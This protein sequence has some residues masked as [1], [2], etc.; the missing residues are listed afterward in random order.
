[1]IFKNLKLDPRSRMLYD[2]NEFI[3]HDNKMFEYHMKHILLVR[4]YAIILNKYLGFNLD[5]KKISFIAL[6]H[7]LFK[8]RSLDPKK[9]VSWH[10]IIIP[11]D[12]NR[13]VRSNLDILEKYELDDY[14]NSDMQYHALSAGIFLYKELHITD[15][16]IIYPV[17]FHS[18]QVISIYETLSKRTQ[19]MIDII[20]LA[21]KLSSNYLRIN[22]REVDVRVDLDKVVFG[23]NGKELNYTLGLFI[24]RLI[25]QGKSEEEQSR[26]ATEYYFNRLCDVNPFI[27]KEYSIKMLGGA[28][29]WPKR[30]SQALMRH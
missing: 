20:M 26:I 14:F 12:T 2:L 27:S 21:D 10:N 18:C 6:A 23:K 1:M 22:F 16:E 5:M 4:K 25:S 8:E 9:E 24:A 29:K 19:N 3:H 28:K 7:D 30:K 11:Q 13:Y 15:P 17:F